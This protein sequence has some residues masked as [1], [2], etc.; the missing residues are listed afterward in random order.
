MAEARTTAFT[1]EEKEILD[2]LEHHHRAYQAKRQEVIALCDA[3]EVEKSKR[4]LL[5]GVTD[6]YLQ[7]FASCEDSLLVNQRNANQ[8]AA[9]AE[10]QIRFTPL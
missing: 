5:D 4:L 8:D 3:G 9:Q 2:R 6:L 1:S 10:R 7:I